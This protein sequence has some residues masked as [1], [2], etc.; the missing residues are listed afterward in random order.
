MSDLDGVFDASA[1]Q[2]PRFRDAIVRELAACTFD[3]QRLRDPLGGQPIRILIQ[4]L[5]DFGAWA[6]PASSETGGPAI[7]YDDGTIALGWRKDYLG[8]HF[9]R[10]KIMANQPKFRRYQRLGYGE[11]TR[12]VILHEAF[13]HVGFWIADRDPEMRR[14][15]DELTPAPY[16]HHEWIPHALEGYSDLSIPELTSADGARARAILG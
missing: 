13:H 15:L 7:G 12:A 2:D 11:W 16:E 8:R 1:V 9:K 6:H 14:K 4:D 3:W 5:G 10:T